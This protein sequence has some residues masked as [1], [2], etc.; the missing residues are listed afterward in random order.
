MTPLRLRIRELREARGWS[1]AEL[2]RRAGIASQIVNRLESGHTRT[3]SLDNLERLATALG[4][5]PGS[6]LTTAP[7]KRAAPR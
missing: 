7:P 2:G 6:L 3:P 1:Q 5:A 4:V